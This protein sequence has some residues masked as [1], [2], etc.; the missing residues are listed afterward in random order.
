MW[1]GWLT[2]IPRLVQWS[3]RCRCSLSV[4][5][6]SGPTHWRS[7]VIILWL[8]QTKCFFIKH[9]SLLP[10]H[11][12]STLFATIYSDGP[13]IQTCGADAQR[14]KKKTLWY[15][16]YY[17]TGCWY[18]KT[19]LPTANQHH[20]SLHH[21]FRFSTRLFFKKV[22][23]TIKTHLEDSAAPLEVCTPCCF[24]PSSFTI[25]HL[26]ELNCQLTNTDPISWVPVSVA[27]PSA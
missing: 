21:W 22:S 10:R 17:K 1:T 15:L 27:W 3:S 2:C 5:V 19:W 6:C 11:I 4:S 18:P 7:D 16:K 26:S 23:D 20:F 8:I 14:K 24:H 9:F 25:L 13:Q 12:R